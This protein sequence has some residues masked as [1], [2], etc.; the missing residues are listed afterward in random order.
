MYA[1]YS[2]QNNQG[3]EKKSSQQKER[4]RQQQDQQQQLPTKKRSSTTSKS[5]HHHLKKND[6]GLRAVVDDLLK[7]HQQTI[8]E[9]PKRPRVTR[10]DSF[11]TITTAAETP[12]GSSCHV[13]V[14]ERQKG[15]FIPLE[16]SFPTPADRLLSSFPQHR[17]SSPK[18]MPLLQKSKFLPDPR[19]VTDFYGESAEEIVF[20]PVESEL[21]SRS[22]SMEVLRKI[23]NGRYNHNNKNSDD[24]DDDSS[25]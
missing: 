4:R 8:P 3:C 22:S 2:T 21:A 9:K 7:D 20:V 16:I 11:S 13:T 14:D 23:S 6:K 24:D 15:R 5:H 10:R 25:F 1:I 19:T 17:Q 18:K 12:S